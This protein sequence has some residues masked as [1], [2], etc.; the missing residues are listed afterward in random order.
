MCLIIYNNYKTWGDSIIRKTIYACFLFFTFLLLVL[1]APCAAQT[2][3]F[4]QTPKVTAFPENAS[5]NPNAGD[6]AADNIPDTPATPPNNAD[7][8]GNAPVTDPGN[9]ADMTTPDNSGDN[10]NAQNGNGKNNQNVDSST[11]LSTLSASGGERSTSGAAASS[12]T[13]TSIQI[14]PAGNSG[15]AVTSIPIE[16]PP[17]RKGIQPNI[18]LN[19]N[20]SGRNGWLGVGWSLDMGAIQRNTKWGVNYSGNDYIYSIA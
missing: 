14:S 16:V 8:N 2:D 12:G 5:D 17:G 10:A 3:T 7:S 19:Y 9:P 18:A 1:V 6:N 13:F 11:T 4:T 20:S 15:A